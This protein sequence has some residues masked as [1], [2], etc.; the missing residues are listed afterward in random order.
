MLKLQGD[1]TVPMHTVSHMR[2]EAVHKFI[3]TCGTTISSKC[4]KVT[5]Y[6]CEG[7]ASH[8]DKLDCEQPAS[9]HA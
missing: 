5:F 9:A 3:T 6:D 2:G 4:L 8:M 1:S 7:R